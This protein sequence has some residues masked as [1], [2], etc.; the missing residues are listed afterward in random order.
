MDASKA[1]PSQKGSKK[2]NELLHKHRTAAHSKHGSRRRKLLSKG[3]LDLSKLSYLNIYP[4]ETP[5][6]PKSKPR[7]PKKIS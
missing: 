3:I 7:P 1:G 2:R 5:L 6:S 4:V